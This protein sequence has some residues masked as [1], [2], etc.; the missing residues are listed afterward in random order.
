MKY[1]IKYTAKLL[2]Q[3]HSTAFNMHAAA[4]MPLKGMLP[5]CHQETLQIH[6]HLLASGVQAVK[7]GM[8]FSFSSKKA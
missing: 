8:A 6:K 5:W 3:S 7:P 4:V 2:K 1:C